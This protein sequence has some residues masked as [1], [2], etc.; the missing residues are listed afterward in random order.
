MPTLLRQVG[1]SL[2]LTHSTS[3]HR[4]IYTP[5]TMVIRES[6]DIGHLC[7]DGTGGGP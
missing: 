3:D 1:R 6:R 2:S 7:A 5:H 4:I